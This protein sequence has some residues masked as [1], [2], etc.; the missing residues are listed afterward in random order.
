MKFIDWLVDKWMQRCRHH[1]S[2]VAA[3]I[4][5]G[6]HDGTEVKYC[7]RC[8]SMRINRAEWRR[9]RPLWFA[10]LA[11]AAF[12]VVIVST[13]EAEAAACHAGVYRS[14]CVSRH[15]AVVRRHGYRY[16]A[17]RCYWRGGRRVCY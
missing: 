2:H 3:D 12:G 4:L 16:G 1:P 9:P 6:A 10:I 11:F 7:R 14:G 13:P 17:N 15:G 8:G 5:E